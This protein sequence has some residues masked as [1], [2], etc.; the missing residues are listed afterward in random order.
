MSQQFPAKYRFVLIESEE[1]FDHRFRALRTGVEQTK[2]KKEKK[3]EKQNTIKN[4]L[5]GASS[6]WRHRTQRERIRREAGV[7]TR[8][9]LTSNN[10]PRKKGHTEVH[11]I[12]SG[13]KVHATL[14]VPQH[15]LWNGAVL[16]GSVDWNSW[17]S[18]VAEIL[19]SLPS[20][21]LG[22]EGRRGTFSHK[23]S[24]SLRSGKRTRKANAAGNDTGPYRLSFSAPFHF[25]HE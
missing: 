22:W 9:A 16:H 20:C 13:V 17:G 18:S 12:R 8:W 1:Q 24:L 19:E 6:K 15:T 10:R 21:F 3:R 14:P 23:R 2:K 4:E 7:E 25:I 11:G 5:R